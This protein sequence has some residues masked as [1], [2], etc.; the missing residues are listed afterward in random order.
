MLISFISPLHTYIP[1][2]RSSPSPPPAATPPLPPPTPHSS[3]NDSSDPSSLPSSAGPSRAGVAGVDY[4]MR[5]K[6]YKKLAFEMA[7]RRYEEL[8][9][10]LERLNELETEQVGREGG[11]EGG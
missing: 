9:P 7:S 1:T 6:E 4:I 2:G 8:R 11:R 3:D 5:E 10:I